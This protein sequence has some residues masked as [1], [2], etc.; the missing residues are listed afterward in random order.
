[1]KNKLLV[2]LV[3]LMLIVPI[4]IAFGLSQNLEVKES[5]EFEISNINVD[6]SELILKINESLLFNYLESLVDIGPRYVGSENCKKAAD[7]IHDEF[8]K[9]G[10]D[11]YIDPWNYP[12]YKC[13]NVVAT[14]NGTDS[15]SDAIFVICAHFDTIGDSPGANDD[16]SGIAAMLSI[17]NILC[18][19]TFNHTIRFVATSGEE[20]GIYGANDY[21][22]KAYLR[23]ENIVGVLNLDTIGYTTEKG[24]NF[25]YLLKPERSSWISSIINELSQTYQEYINLIPLVL[26][27][28]NNDHRAFLNYGYDALQF[29]Q[30]S[31]GDYPYHTPEDKIEK[32]NFTYL[33]KVTRLIF[34]TILELANRPIDVQVRFVTPKEGYLY[35]FDRPL[36]RQ[37]KVNILGRDARG[38]TYIIGRTTARINI[39]TKEEIISVSYSIDGIATFSG[40]FQESPY[41]WKIKISNDIFPLTGKHTLGVQVCSSSGKTAYDEMDI[42]IFSTY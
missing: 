21:A 3:L 13:R 18:K 20:V 17:A 8:E 39:T 7:Y 23:D 30:L 37:P 34:A 22:R 5:K 16:G 24:G 35:L 36:L 12:R 26:N 33:K 41:E 40:F 32:V 10:L 6:I 11:V 28:R 27:N 25:C 42:Y 19:Y 31:R 15:S 1:M 4:Q 14:L 29:V 38:L 2:I 9:L